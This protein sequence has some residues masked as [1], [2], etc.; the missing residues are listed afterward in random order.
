MTVSAPTQNVF[1]PSTISEIP[2]PWTLFIADWTQAVSMVVPS[3]L[4]PKSINE[5]KA[6]IPPS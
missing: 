1:P 3:P 5:G 4:Q 6:L 2:L